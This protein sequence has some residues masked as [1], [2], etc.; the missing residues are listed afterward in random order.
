MEN[1]EGEAGE[2]SLVQGSAPDALEP[3]GEVFSQRV[4]YIVPR[5]ALFKMDG[6]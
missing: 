1:F 5:V 6:V 2:L 4:C 3:A